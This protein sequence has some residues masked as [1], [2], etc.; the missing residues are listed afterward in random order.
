MRKQAFSLN[1]R[2]I[3]TAFL[4]TLSVSATAEDSFR[5]GLAELAAGSF[6]KAAATLA[7][8]VK[9]NPEHPA[10]VQAMCGN[11]Q[12]LSAM[13]RNAEAADVFEAALK[14][15]TNRVREA[16]I[17]LSC[18]KCQLHA[19]RYSAAAEHAHQAIQVSTSPSERAAAYPMLISALC[20]DERC[21]EAWLHLQKGADSG[22]LDPNVTVSLAKK[23]AAGALKQ[24]E[25]K[26]ACE[27]FGWQMENDQD[28]RGKQEAALGYAWAQAALATTPTEAAEALLEYVDNYPKSP[29]AARALLAA[30]R[31]QI[32]ADQTPVAIE[33]LQRL[34]AQYADAS[35]TV[36][37]LT[38]LIQIAQKAGDEELLQETRAHLA[39]QHTDT[40]AARSVLHLAIADA[41]KSG[42]DAKFEAVASVVFNAGDPQLVAQ[43]LDRLS[44]TAGNEIVLR[45][46]DAGLQRMIDPQQHI[47][48]GAIIDWLFEHQHWSVITE[49]TAKMPAEVLVSNQY[50]GAVIAESLQRLGSSKA[51]YDLFT[52]LAAGSEP[53]FVVLL[54]R[55][56]LAVQVGSV[57]EATQA[58]AAATAAAES[59]R[60]RQYVQIVAAQL[61]IRRADFDSSRKL[62]DT[63]VL[64]PAADQRLR[65]RAQWLIG[66]TYFMQRDYRA[67]I[68][69]YRRCETLF[70][71]SG[72]GAAALLQAGKAFEKMGNF[73]DAAVCYTSLLNKHAKSPYA[74]LASRRLG[75]IGNE[76]T[77]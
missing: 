45:F 30:A 66:E 47:V 26:T 16:P 34:Y 32:D 49:A 14:Q 39:Q 11:G 68:D 43:T 15:R 35:E 36:D 54:R 28:D 22:E 27:A 1:L 56:E 6:E 59:S 72:W 31:K 71:E 61:A 4:I 62:L 52:R 8:F 33:L 50:Q 37:G 20:E 58:I 21:S 60:D 2:T 57:D 25:A 38:L 42:D 18:A 10:A 48:T 75:W 19:G 40:P 12:A 23:V 76:T 13:G 67:A 44:E 77:R 3:F 64:S 65:G 46:A 55:S 17:R 51:A 70:P 74:R 41:A 5:A 24:G 7:E 73:R 53:T 9:K 63:V 69:A 29:G